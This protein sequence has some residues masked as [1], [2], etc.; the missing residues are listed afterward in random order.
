MDERGDKMTSLKISEN[1]VMLRHKKG[2]TQDQLADFLGVTKASVSKWENNQSFPDIMLLPK[3]AS[4]FDISID[5][6]MGYEPQL[7]P[8]QIRKCY[9]DLASDFARLPFDKAMERSRAIVKQYYSCYPLL[10]EIVV[11][12]INHFMLSPDKEVQKAILKDAEELCDR[13]LSSSIDTALKSH[14][15]VLKGLINLQ[16]GKPQDVIDTMEPIVNSINMDFQ[17]D[18]ILIQAYQLSG[19]ISKAELYSQVSIYLHLGNL[20]SS[21]MGLVNIKMQSYEYCHETIN[22]IRK[23][24]D[25]YDVEKLNPNIALQFHYQC[26]MVYCVHEKTEEALNEL[27]GFVYGCIA[28]LEQGIKLHGDEYFNRLDE[29]FDNLENGSSP[30]RNE[31]VVMESLVPAIN[32]PVFSKLFNNEKY[33]ELKA[34]IERKAEGVKKL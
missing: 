18:G 17:A 30:P 19:D 7:S 5:E 16:Q 4:Y 27:E 8:E 26:A 3:L 29:W 23:L 12:W 21:S 13:V 10:S 24:M 34:I 25:A 22:R 32:N 20:I 15:T 9:S 31:K 11:L 6:L 1:I 28:F 33:K 2:I 14:T